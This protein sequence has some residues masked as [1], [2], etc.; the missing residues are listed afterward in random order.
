MDPILRIASRSLVAGG[1]F[2]VGDLV[3]FGKYKNKKA[4]IRG[5]RVD[6]RGVP[7]VTL[8]PT[9]KGR[10][11]DKEM[12]LFNIWHADPEKRKSFGV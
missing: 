10:K 4:I 3:V 1:Y 11:Q 9:P 12:G 5:I 7:M 2:N 8:E 6:D